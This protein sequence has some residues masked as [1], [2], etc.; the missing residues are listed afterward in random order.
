MNYLRYLFCCIFMLI[1]S[2]GYA[3]VYITISAKLIRPA[4]IVTAENG[5]KE[6][7]INFNEVSFERLNDSKKSFGILVKECDLKKVYK[8]ISLPEKEKPS[9]LMMRFY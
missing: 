8:Y 2:P 5:E 4:C 3:D 9:V 1:A 7:F 6:L